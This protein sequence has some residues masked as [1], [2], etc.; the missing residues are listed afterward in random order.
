MLDIEAVKKAI[1]IPDF[2]QTQLLEIALTHPSRI[3]E[4]IL[5]TQQQK[6]LK[7]REYRRLAILGDSILGAV[8]ID[9]LHQ[10]F[11]NLNQGEI[12]NWKSHLV[13]RNQVSEF[14]QKFNLKQLCLLGRGEQW[15]DES[16]QVE[17]FGEMFE[18][19]F[20]AIYLEFAR[21]FSLA[22][23]WLVERF[24][25]K[26]V[27]DLLTDTPI[28]NNQ[29]SEDTMQELSMMNSA[30]VTEKL[31]AVRQEIEE[32]LLLPVALIG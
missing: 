12:T 30:E 17:L 24:I 32:K 22:R 4:N 20:G 25:E 15:R 5:L 11:S 13:S 10:R 28:T 29:F 16:G 31:R 7:E 1:G 6:A 9:Y 19:L 8:V 27:N 26:A 2:K 18:A 14:A 3:Y 21:D 23:N